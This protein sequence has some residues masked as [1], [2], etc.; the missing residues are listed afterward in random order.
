MTASPKPGF[1]LF[2]ETLIAGFTLVAIVLHVILAYF[3]LDPGPHLKLAA[4]YRI[5]SWRRSHGVGTAEEISEA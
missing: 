3:F 4:V 1:A 5:D 2:K